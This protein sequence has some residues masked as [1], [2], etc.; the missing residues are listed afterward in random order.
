VDFVQDAAEAAKAFPGI[1]PANFISA[2]YFKDTDLIKQLVTIKLKLDSVQE[3]VDDTL[4]AV[5]SEAMGSSLEV[6]SLVQ[7]QADRVPGLKSVA[8]KLKARFKKTKGK[9]IPTPA[10]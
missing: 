4:M 1:L 9:D 3:K 2:E 7:T 5:G 8:D 10:V 6:Y